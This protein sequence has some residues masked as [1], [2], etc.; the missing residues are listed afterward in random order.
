M[1]E[2][3]GIEDADTEAASETEAVVAAAAAAVVVADT[4]FAAAEI[5]VG[6]VTLVLVLDLAQSIV[7]IV[8]VPVE[9][10]HLVLP[11][12]VDPV[13]HSVGTAVPLATVVPMMHQR[14]VAEG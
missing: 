9:A 11:E 6:S 2:C 4:V 1:L 13:D 10:I 14:L 7:G 8:A 12:Q 5:T 3:A